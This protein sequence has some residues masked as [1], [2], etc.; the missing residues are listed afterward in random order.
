MLVTAADLHARITTQLVRQVAISIPL[1]FAL[2]DREYVARARSFGDDVTF[3][4]LLFQ[5]RSGEGHIFVI[6]IVLLSFLFRY[7]PPSQGQTRS[8]RADSYTQYQPF[9]E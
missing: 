2:V 1:H 4:H 6:G 8:E 3:L 9:H 5:A 7:R